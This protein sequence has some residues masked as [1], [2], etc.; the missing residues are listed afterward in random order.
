M[1][2][3]NTQELEKVKTANAPTLAPRRGSGEARGVSTAQED[4]IV[5]LIYVLQGLSPQVSK[6]NDSYI[7]GAEPGDI[8]LR[9]APEPV[10]KGAEGLIF[11]PCY[12]YKHWVEWIPREAG[13]GFMGTHATMPAAAKKVEDDEDPNLV[14]YVMPNGNEVKETRYHVGLVYTDHGSLP[15]VIPLS[16]SGHTVSRTFMSLMANKL[17]ESGQRYDSFEFKYKLTTKLRKNKKGEWFV[18]EPADFERA[19]DEEFAKGQDL[20]NAFAAGIKK[21][22]AE[23]DVGSAG[24]KSTERM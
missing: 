2:K 4:N 10:V 6:R 20:Y 15:Y 19:N 7:E 14:K 13:G 18:F 3:S 17:D 11:Q 21:A 8:W 9:N 5:P 1:A 22:D 23:V 24:D 12:F 16:G